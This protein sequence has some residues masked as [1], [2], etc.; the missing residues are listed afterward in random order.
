VKGVG[1]YTG[2]Q[3]KTF[4]ILPKALT[5]AMVTLDKT[6]FIYNE[7]VQKPEVTVADGTIM[8]AED[9]QV[10]NDGGT[11]EGTYQVVVTGQNNYKG[12]VIKS[13][14]ITRE[15]IHGDDDPE[16]PDE[17]PMTYTPTE[18]DSDEVKVSGYEG[19]ETEL[20]QITSVS[21]PATCTAN[22]KTYS[23]VG[24]AANAFANIPNL[25]DIYLPDTEEPLE[26]AEDAI[27]ASATV[28][29]T[30]ALLDDYALMPSLS[31]NFKGG[32]I[33]TEVTAKNRYWTFSSGVDVYV[34]DGVSVYIAR[35][36]SSAS[37]TIVELS[38]NDLTVSGQRIIKHNN[39]VLISSEGN[40]TPYD[41]VA[42]GRRMSSGSMISTDDYKDYGSQN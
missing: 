33:K 35:E 37:V 38:D 9:Y 39:G 20:E 16:H 8:T 18:E 3:V 17:K 41:L 5:D 14:T 10:T 31:E 28:H 19:T 1:D 42:C 12:V 36:R 30:L 32:K 26:I 4:T 2:E 34:P 27:P 13:F 24:I 21:I 6:S 11:E 15:D 40:D 29:T 22:G 7:K 23:V 25:K